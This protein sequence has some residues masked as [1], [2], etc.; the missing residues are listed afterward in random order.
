MDRAARRHRLVTATESSGPA[1][2][3]GPPLTQDDLTRMLACFWHPVCTVAELAATSSGVLGVRLLGR[4]LAVARVADGTP[5]ALVDRCLHR[6]A[7]LSVGWVDGDAIRCAYHGWRWAGDGHCVEIPSAP[8]TPIPGRFCQEAFGSAERYGM[9]WVRLD[10]RFPTVIPA[11]PAAEDPTMRIVT[12]EPY[13][14]PTA[15]PRR[16]ENFVDLAHFAWV[17]DGTLGRR[18]EPVPPSPTLAR[19]DGELRFH[20]DPPP[21]EEQPDTALVGV[22]DYRL[23]IP[24][25]VNIDFEIAGLAGVRRHLW[26][27]ASPVDPGTSRSFWTVARNDGHDE[28]DEPHL[29]FQRIVLAEDEPVV[30]NQ[31]PPE[32][33]LDPGAELSVKSDRVSVEYRR[34]LV[35]LTR[36]LARGAPDFAAALAG[37]VPLA[38]HTGGS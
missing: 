23:P 18:D 15:A 10:D 27:T 20:F 5:V 22:S 3:D 25:T 6:S 1:A 29:E 2:L 13:T 34:W 37:A 30:C 31:V 11:M 26:M 21:I 36:A 24:L 14:W 28:P 38:T 35:E 7:R 12:G 17:H 33:P 9:I 16:V 19:L 8:T 32:L 4:D